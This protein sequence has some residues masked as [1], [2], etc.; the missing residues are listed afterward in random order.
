M[1]RTSLGTCNPAP[2]MS[3]P[4]RSSSPTA[5]IK[6]VCSYGGKILPRYPDG[7]LR[8]YGGETR[9]LSVNRS[10]TFAELMVKMSE[11]CG[12]AM[13][14]RCQLP[15]EDLDALV[16]ITSEEDLANIIE[17]YDRAAPPP[18]C[19]KIKAF[20]SLLRS[21]KKISPPSSPASSSRSPAPRYSTAIGFNPRFSWKPVVHRP[22]GFPLCM[23]RSAVKMPQFYGRAS[24]GHV[25]LVHNGKHC[26]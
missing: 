15:T 9:V 19:L 6:F 2:K 10:I 26:Q 17:E 12:T 24:H 25:Y 1:V 20:I 11:L 16:S 21:A 13:S 8:Y 14:L 7:K 3:P 18:T 4:P 23:E 22:M 5:T